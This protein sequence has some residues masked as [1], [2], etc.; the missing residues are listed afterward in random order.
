[1]A[2]VLA[3]T[4]A[5]AATSAVAVTSAVAATSAVATTLLLLLAAASFNTAAGSC[6]CRDD[7][8]EDCI[9]DIPAEVKLPLVPLFVPPIA[10]LTSSKP[11]PPRLEFGLLRLPSTILLV[12][13]GAAYTPVTPLA[14]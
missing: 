13:F 9:E 10:L 12:S 1:M 11:P 8:D 6:G 5:V 3:Q 4:S 14:L 7:V 2:L